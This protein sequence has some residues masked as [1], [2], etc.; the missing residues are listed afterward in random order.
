M[1]TLSIKLGNAAMSDAPDV[2]K[3][4][5]RVARD[6]DAGAFSGIIWDDNGN[7]VGTYEMVEVSE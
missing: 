6:I 1:F 5:R 7:R 3:A 2:S 4:L